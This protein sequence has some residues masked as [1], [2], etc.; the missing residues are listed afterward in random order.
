L[1]KKYA[2]R[3]YIHKNKINGK[4]Y[5]G[6]TTTNPKFRWGKNGV[7]YKNQDKF[8]N[9]IQKYGWNNF[10]HIIL[11][12][13]YKTKET[14]DKAEIDL[15]KD[16]DSVDNGYNVSLGGKSPVFTQ[17]TR[18]K[19][20]K[21]L[22]GVGNKKISVYNLQ[23]DFMA[24]FDSLNETMEKLELKSKGLISSVLKGDRGMYAGYTFKYY[25]KNDDTIKYFTPQKKHEKQVDQYDLNNNFIK[26]HDSIKEAT[27]EV[28][29]K[30]NSNITMVCK[31]QRN[32]A[33]GYKWM[34]VEVSE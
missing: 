29:G 3:I 20:S 5:V 30:S 28:N 13:V 21:K 14:L 26:R 17:E 4:C 6:Q 9:A 18:D 7:K 19:L 24:T 2:G 15:I 25:E 22:K 33:H 16:L 8:Y 23:G 31:G 34:Y 12:T 11:P 27:K 32:T 1:D 10:E